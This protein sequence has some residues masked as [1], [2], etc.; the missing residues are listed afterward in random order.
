M[1]DKSSKQPTEMDHEIGQRL[2]KWRLAQDVDA[3]VL[4]EKLGVSYQQLQKYEKGQ[5]RITASRLY[6]IARTLS[7]P[8]QWFFRE[9][10]SQDSLP[11]PL[12]YRTRV[13]AANT[14]ING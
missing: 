9:E 1:T 7:V 10:T 8:V 6:E 2:R 4:A 13:N 5:T 11:D 12:G 3:C 14:E